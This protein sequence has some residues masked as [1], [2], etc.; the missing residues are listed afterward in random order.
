MSDE[1][2]E[3]IEPSFRRTDPRPVDMP[4][5]RTLPSAP[6]LAA[7]LFAVSNLALRARLIACLLRP[8]GPL[9]LAG[10]AA[11]AFAGFLTRSERLQASVDLARVARVSSEQIL[12]L[13]RFV[14]EVEPQALLHFAE[15]I[16]GSHLGLA[17]FSASVL[18]LLYRA[19][20]ERTPATWPT[21]MGSA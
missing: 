4:A 10:V 1:F 17:T 3:L 2:D 11:G 9:G 8:L 14:E 12:D 7:R 20:R 13:A 21:A 19:L 15:L 18:A 5:A 6:R 16:S